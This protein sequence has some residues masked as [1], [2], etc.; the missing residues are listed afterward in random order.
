MPQPVKPLS[1]L[2]IVVWLVAT[3]L[4]AQDAKAI[5]E[6]AIAAIHAQDIRAIE[7]NGRGFDALF[8]QAYDGDSAWPR[9]ALTHF[10]L[11]IDYRDNFLRD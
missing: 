10:S 2:S 8:G 9:F 4:H 6:Q 3:P 7:I 11:A 1:W 5:V